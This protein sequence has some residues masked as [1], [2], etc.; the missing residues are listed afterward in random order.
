MATIFMVMATLVTA[1]A[2][3]TRATVMATRLSGDCTA[4]TG[5]FAQAAG[6][7]TGSL[8]EAGSSLVVG[9]ALP[10]FGSMLLQRVW[11]QSDRRI[12][13]SVSRIVSAGVCAISSTALS[14]TRSNGFSSTSGIAL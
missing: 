6:L 12:F 3:V 9:S 14:T 1:M 2:T 7:T 4:I 13:N 5:D 11:P 10:Q 8:C